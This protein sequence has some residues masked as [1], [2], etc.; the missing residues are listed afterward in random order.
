MT[1]L[2][3]EIVRVVS[4]LL[5]V[6]GVVGNL[7]T[8]YVCMRHRLR[9]NPTFIYLF[10]ISLN[11]IICQLVWNIDQLLILL[12]FDTTSFL[13]VQSAF[14]ALAWCKTV[15]FVEYFTLEYSAWLL[16]TST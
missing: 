4:S 13:S 16:V 7:L 5:L 2:I 8:C 9:L 15:L 1:T 11:G 10:F 3:H 12:Q 6:C 14:H